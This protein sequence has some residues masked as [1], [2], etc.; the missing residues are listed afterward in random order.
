MA[1]WVNGTRMP[2]FRSPGGL[3]AGAG[4]AAVHAERIMTSATRSAGATC[5]ALLDEPLFR[6]VDELVGVRLREVDV[7]V[8]DDVVVE[9]LQESELELGSALQ[10]LPVR[11]EHPHAVL[12]RLHVSVLV[13][14]VV[15][16]RE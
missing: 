1:D 4:A 10:H 2:I 11:A 3:A 6:G 14:A 7:R 9:L 8:L 16:G 13:A 12:E 15:V 5:P